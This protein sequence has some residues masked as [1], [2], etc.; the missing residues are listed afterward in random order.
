[1]IN[2]TEWNKLNNANFAEKIYMAK[3]RFVA[4]NANTQLLFRFR[5]YT[6]SSLKKK[7]N[8]QK[9]RKLRYFTRILN[10]IRK[11]PARSSIC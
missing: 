2:R 3:A 6:T 10:L 11:L 5:K 4:D 8:N 9:S 7:N 1:M